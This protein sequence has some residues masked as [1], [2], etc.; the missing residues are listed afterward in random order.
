MMYIRFIAKQIISFNVTHNS[1]NGKYSNT[2][3]AVQFS[4]HYEKKFVHRTILPVSFDGVKTDKFYC[5]HL[6][7]KSLPY[8]SG[9]HSAARIKKNVSPNIGLET[10]IINVGAGGTGSLCPSFL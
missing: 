7:P 8:A 5:R 3:I 9:V 2:L 4:N 10:T 6:W 1:F